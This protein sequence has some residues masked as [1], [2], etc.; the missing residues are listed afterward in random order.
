MDHSND[1]AQEPLTRAHGVRK[2]LTTS[3]DVGADRRD[4]AAS[5]EAGLVVAR[6]TWLLEDAADQVRLRAQAEGVMS[7]R[8]PLALG[9]EIAACHAAN[10]LPAGFVDSEGPERLPADALDGLVAAE[11]LTRSLP[12]DSLPAGTSHL[13]VQL[14]ELVGEATAALGAQRPTPDRTQP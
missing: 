8:H 11:A 13:V 7:A 6:V 3:S 4:A 12:I 14:C 5:S 9:V 2:A 10:L 1:R